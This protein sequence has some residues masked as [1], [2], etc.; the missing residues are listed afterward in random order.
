VD[1]G[2]NSASRWL[3]EIMPTDPSIE[4]M[5]QKYTDWIEEEGKAMGLDEQVVRSYELA[6]PLGMSADGLMRYWKKVRTAG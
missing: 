1:K 5:R 2:L 3:E 4:Q 6:N